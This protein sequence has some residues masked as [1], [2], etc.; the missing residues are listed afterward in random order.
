MTPAQSKLLGYVRN[1]IAT[2]DYSPSYDEMATAMGVASKSGIHR[3]I[4]GLMAAG[5]VRMRF[6]S[7]RSIEIIG[8]SADPTRAQLA[9]KI[10]KLLHE[11]HAVDDGEAPEDL[12]IICTKAEAKATILRALA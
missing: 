7:A 6:G 10:V 3:I 2:H 9:D 11:V 1:Y 12:L 8:V 4:H 5:K